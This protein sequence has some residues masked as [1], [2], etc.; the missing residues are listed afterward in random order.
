[1]LHFLSIIKCFLKLYVRRSVV[2]GKLS[3]RSSVEICS[4]FYECLQG[5]CGLHPGLAWSYL[6]TVKSG[7]SV[8][9]LLCRQERHKNSGVASYRTEVHTRLSVPRRLLA[10]YIRAGITWVAIPCKLGFAWRSPGPTSFQQND[11]TTAVSR[12]PS[13]SA[14]SF[15]SVVIKR[16]LSTPEISVQ[17]F[18]E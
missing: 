14:L 18:G 17:I 10:S 11:V 6:A 8:R 13:L 15:R 7:W 3:F 12:I 9:L 4:N 5:L 2:E 1:M 16:R